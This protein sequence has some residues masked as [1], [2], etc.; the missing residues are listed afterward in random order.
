MDDNLKRALPL[1]AAGIDVQQIYFTLV[2]EEGI[3]MFAE[4]MKVL[5][6]YVVPKSNVPFEWRIFRQ[7][8]LLSDETLDQFV[9]RPRLRAASCDFGVREDDCIRDQVICKCY[10][11]HFR[12]KFLEQEGNTICLLKIARAQMAVSRQLREMEQ[13]SN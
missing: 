1:H 9:C 5:D 11:S 4:T 6:D 3:A 12:R 13:K 2:S 10:S 7:V 8:A